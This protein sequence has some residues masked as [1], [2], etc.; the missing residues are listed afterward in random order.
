MVTDASDRII[1]INHAFTQL[2]DYSERKD[3]RSESA[4]FCGPNR[5]RSPAH[6]ISKKPCGSAAAGRRAARQA[7]EWRNIPNG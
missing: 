6:A 1:A 4:T 5:R 3:P 7:Q 2:T